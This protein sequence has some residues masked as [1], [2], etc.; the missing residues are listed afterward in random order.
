MITF[1]DINNM[2]HTE[3]Y[4][5]GSK[6]WKLSELC[7]LNEYNG[8]YFTFINPFSKIKP[9]DEDYASTYGITLISANTPTQ[10][11]NTITARYNS[12]GSS[13][14]NPQHSL[15]DCSGID[16][17]YATKNYKVSDFVG[18]NY[19]AKNPVPLAFTALNRPTIYFYNGKSSF[20]GNIAD[21]H[22]NGT[23][24]QVGFDDLYGSITGTKQRGISIVNS[25]GVAKLYYDTIDLSNIDLTQWPSTNNS[26]DVFEFLKIGSKFYA[27]PESKSNVNLINMNFQAGDPSEYPTIE[28][29]DCSIDENGIL[30][31]NYRFHLTDEQRAQYDLL[32][33]DDPTSTKLPKY[34]TLYVG[35]SMY[36]YSEYGPMSFEN[37]VP[38]TAT[39][40]IEI[41]QERSARYGQGLAYGKLIDGQ[42]EEVTVDGW[43]V[44]NEDNTDYEL[45]NDNDYYMTGTIDLHD[46]LIDISGSPYVYLHYGNDL[47][48]YGRPPISLY[49]LEVENPLCTITLSGG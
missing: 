8:T 30:T 2:L 15:K 49:S 47:F 9:M 39:N 10:L 22:I 26:Y 37:G 19:N 27:L 24:E 34:I 3:K 43:M 21:T 35:L 1:T 5:G 38:P 20:K 46:T 44:W 42:Y 7:G 28:F 31:Y 33:P 45:V 36:D 14:D 4:L 25:G 40:Y 17:H 23:S 6:H 18:Y 48:R 16:F 41:M 12:Y 29:G 11:Y 32:D 13:S